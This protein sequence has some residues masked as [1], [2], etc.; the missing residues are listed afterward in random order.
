MK[1]TKSLA[2]LAA[3]PMA[4]ALSG[5]ATPAAPTLYTMDMT[6]SDN[7]VTIA[8]PELQ[9]RDGEKAVV[10]IA[11]PDG[12]SYRAELTFTRN[13][14]GTIDM[15]SQI[16]ATSPTIGTVSFAPQLTLQLGQP[17]RI[18][19]GNQTPGVRPLRIELKLTQ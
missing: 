7:G 17:A 18:E 12:R 19:Y 14:E 5:F 15:T 3:I 16:D 11:K 9:L 13:D 6:L 1:R 2:T 4:F 8:E 10:E